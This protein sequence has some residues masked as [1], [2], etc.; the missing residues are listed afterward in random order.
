MVSSQ[1]F[2]VWCTIFGY[3][4]VLWLQAAALPTM[5]EHGAPASHTPDG[6]AALRQPLLLPQLHV[7]DAR[8]TAVD[9]SSE[10]N[11]SRASGIGCT[12]YVLCLH[13]LAA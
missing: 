6:G 11:A 13:I 10:S 12:H 4:A 7:S 3:A 5:D 9:C 1:P 8:A 2:H